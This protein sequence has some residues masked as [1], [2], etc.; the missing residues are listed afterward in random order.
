MKRKFDFIIW[1]N[2]DYYRDIFRFY[3]RQTHV[4]SFND[5]P[6]K[7]WKEVY[8][9]Y[10]SWAIIR[11]YYDENGKIFSSAKLFNMDFDECSIIPDLYGIINY[12]D[13]T[14]DIYD[15]PTWG[16][17]AADWTIQKIKISENNIYYQFYVFNN[18]TNQGYRFRLDSDEKDLF[19]KYLDS[20]NEYA[21]AHGEAI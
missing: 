5:V 8:K 9:V 18:V 17:P 3:P 1:D 6:P 20:I 15:M 4:H 11:Q 13:E 10:Y 7:S 16:Q 19:C 2:K 21:L 14:E 12:V